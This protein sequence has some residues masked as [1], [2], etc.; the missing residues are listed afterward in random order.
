MFIKKFKYFFLFVILLI[1]LASYLHSSEEWG[2]RENLDVDVI[3]SGQLLSTIHTNELHHA[4]YTFEK[5]LSPYVKFSGHPA[6][7]CMGAITLLVQCSSD[8]V[9]SITIP[10]QNE[11][12]EKIVFCSQKNSKLHS[13]VPSDERFVFSPKEGRPEDEDMQNFL[14]KIGHPELIG[15][16]TFALKK[17]R[18]VGD[19]LVEETKIV[20]SSSKK[21]PSIASSDGGKSSIAS[22]GGF[23][24]KFQHT[25][26][27]LIYY[28]LNNN[29]EKLRNH[30]HQ[31]L[32]KIYPPASYNFSNYY[33][34]IVGLILHVHT[35]LD[36]CSNCNDSLVLFRKK[37]LEILNTL[38]NE[39]AGSEEASA[40]TS[41]KDI[42]QNI[43]TIEAPVLVTV[44]SRA[45]NDTNREM[46][47]Y[48]EYWNGAH[49][50]KNHGHLNIQLKQ[51]ALIRR[52]DL[53][54][55]LER[56]DGIELINTQLES[57]MKKESSEE[58]SAIDYTNPSPNCHSIFPD[59]LQRFVFR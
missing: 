52:I 15:A 11:R 43:P 30:I 57:P 10:I 41:T 54:E 6:N 32:A 49:D 4:M 53:R 36:V 13:I 33:G 59:V 21:R 34:N 8:R 18:R 58:S 19:S 27:K 44:S 46:A 38:P 16:S 7:I 26:Q 17:Y 28:L 1:K 51:E 22:S 23:A 5:K 20:E 35:R 3:I 47:G 56:I 42:V 48:D 37:A 45:R 25:E 12:Y 29:G 40:L 50:R 31:A 24:M 9:Y 2:W 14:G 55:D 39:D